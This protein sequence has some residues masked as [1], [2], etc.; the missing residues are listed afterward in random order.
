MQITC[1]ICVTGL[2]RLLLQTSL[3][4]PATVHIACILAYSRYG[5]VRDAGQGVAAAAAAGPSASITR[6]VQTDASQRRRAPAASAY[7]G[8]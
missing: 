6:S 1:P 2:N 7:P 3:A 4:K 8:N 5:V